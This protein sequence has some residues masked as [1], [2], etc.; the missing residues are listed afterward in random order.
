MSPTIFFTQRG[1]RGEVE[2][3]ASKSD[4]EIS[5]QKVKEPHAVLGWFQLLL[6]LLLQRQQQ[7]SNL[8][9]ASP[10]ER[11]EGDQKGWL[12]GTFVPCQES[13]LLKHSPLV[14]YCRWDP[15][16]SSLSCVHKIKRIKF[17]PGRPGSGHCGEKK[18]ILA[19]YRG[20]KAAAARRK[21]RIQSPLNS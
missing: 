19:R 21:K 5:S 17:W 1:R 13:R 11:R 4:K 20:K 9:I 3:V 18:V 7:A 16:N 6:L 12:N 14:L 8:F 2:A 10:V 15:N